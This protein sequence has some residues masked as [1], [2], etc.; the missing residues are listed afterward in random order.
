[1][2]KK[3]LIANIEDLSEG[4]ALNLNVADC[5]LVITKHQNEIIAYENQCPHQ[6]KPLSDV[7]QSPYDQDGDYL[8]CDHHGALFSPATGACITGPCQGNH[9]KRVTIGIEKG[10]CYLLR[11]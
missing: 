2:F 4:K 6:N 9:L 1:M 8:K 7:G 11:T 5:H 10:R 3:H